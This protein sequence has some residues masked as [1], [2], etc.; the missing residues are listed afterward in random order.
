VK[1]FDENFDAAQIK[2]SSFKEDS[3]REEII[4]PILKHLGYSAFT[5][6]KIIRSQCLAHPYI[7]FGTK[8]EHISIIPDYVLQVGEKN[9]FVLDAKA[10]SEKNNNR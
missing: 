6:N 10:P 5:E 3:V 7:Q 4:A 1:I 8:L 2:A 9:T